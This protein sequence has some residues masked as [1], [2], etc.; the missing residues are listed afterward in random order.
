VRTNQVLLSFLRI[1]AIVND[2]LICPLPNS[3]PVLIEV[4]ANNPKLVITDGYHFSK[5]V[6]LA[7]RRPNTYYFKVICI[8]DDLQ[9]IFGGILMATLYLFGYFTGF[10]LIKLL[11]FAPILYFLF[12]Y[13]INRKEFL[14]ITRV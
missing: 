13:Y 12:V 11:S 3:K 9:L 10:L 1:R 14:K 4:E 8:I 5:P 7:V 6:E 2:K